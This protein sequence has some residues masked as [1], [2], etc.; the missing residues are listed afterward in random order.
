MLINA[1]LLLRVYKY[2]YYWPLYQGVTTLCQG[3]MMNSIFTCQNWYYNYFGYSQGNMEEEKTIFLS[4]ITMFILVVYK[5]WIRKLANCYCNCH[6]L[7]VG[8]SWTLCKFLNIGNCISN[9]FLSV[10]IEMVCWFPARIWLFLFL[11]MI[12][13]TLSFYNFIHLFRQNPK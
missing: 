6:L 5:N 1:I 8:T 13:I 7:K 2:S 11:F 9:I 4:C 3:T 10:K 12:I